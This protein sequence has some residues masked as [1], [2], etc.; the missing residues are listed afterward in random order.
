MMNF[1]ENAVHAL[2]FHREVTTAFL[3]CARACISG[4]SQILYVY[5]AEVYPTEVRGLGLGIATAVGSVGSIVMPYIAQVRM[6]VL[7]TCHVT[8]V[9]VIV[10]TSVHRSALLHSSDQC[11]PH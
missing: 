4:S 8:F 6:C 3:F 7:C 11:F 5:T 2:P 1:R 10:P 9:C